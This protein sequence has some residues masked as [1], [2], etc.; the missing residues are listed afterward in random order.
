M[1]FVHIPEYLFKMF[2]R[3][4]VC[5][6]KLT[7]PS[8]LSSI[9]SEEDVIKYLLLNTAV[10]GNPNKFEIFSACTLHASIMDSAHKLQPKM[11]LLAKMNQLE[12]M[13]SLVPSPNRAF[14]ELYDLDGTANI[15]HP[16]VILRPIYVDAETVGIV[17]CGSKENTER[18]DFYVRLFEVMQKY[19]SSLD[20]IKTSVYGRYLGS[21]RF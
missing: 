1:K 9:V 2:E 8:E 7:N 19:M 10:A 15:D 21:L 16:E 17:W 14:A 20:I 18:T 5:L 3:D 6:S 13:S 11:E 4:N 12:L